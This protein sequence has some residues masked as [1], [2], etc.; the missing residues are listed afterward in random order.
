MTVHAIKP[1][2]STLTGPTIDWGS[3]YYG[4]C[5]HVMEDW[6]A[7][8]ADLI[9][10]DPPFNSNRDYSILYGTDP[11][12]GRTA[13]QVAFEDTWT[14]DNAA[15]ERQARLERLGLAREDIRDMARGLRHMLGPCPMLSYLTY[16][17][18]RLIEMRRVL[19]LEGSIYLHCDPTASHYL[20]A[21]MDTVFG[22]D[23]FRREIIWKMPRPSG[24]KA[25]A[26][27]W[28][29]NHDTLLFYAGDGAVFNKQYEPYE[30]SYKAK[31]NRRDADGPYWLRGGKK[32]RLGDGYNIGSV[33][34]DIHS[35]QT[36]SVSA[37]EG[38]GYPTQKPVA[39]L[40]RIIA[41]SSNPGDRVLDPF[42]GCGTSVAAAHTLGRQWAG[43]DL[44]CEGL[45]LTRDERLLPAGVQGVPIHGIPADLESARLLAD[46][47]PFK[48]ERWMVEQIDGLWPNERQTGD[49]GIDG[50]G[51][52][53]PD[54]LPIVAQVFA[55]KGQP[56]LSK[57]RDFARC[58]ER[59]NAAVGLFLTVAGQPSAGARKEARAL[60]QHRPDGAARGYPRLQ[61]FSAAD[62]F[63]GRR[64]DLP[65]MQH[66]VTGKPVEEPPRTIFTP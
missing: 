55:G 64:P 53:H 39:L 19:T 7:D 16:M 57:V 42:C 18:E 38:L 27:N 63:A 56:P 12:T 15:A 31:F 26:Q 32:R 35:M 58:I 59:E 34:T 40:E 54:N 46:T 52:T 10:L 33:W 13:Q 60:G 14:W 44:S 61:F 23:R 2:A 17:A 36:Q 45:R 30:P 62:L 47:D 41:A 43:I 25:A 24:Y 8:Q 48:F 11:D 65:Q 51:V 29:R 1:A 6:G 28:I 66:P 20:K 49:G 3:L 21:V 5:L 4:D 9:Y 22:P 37:K 50:R